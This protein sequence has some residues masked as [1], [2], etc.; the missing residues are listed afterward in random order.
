MSTGLKE[1]RILSGIYPT[2]SREDGGRRSACVEINLLVTISTTFRC[3]GTILART[4]A[5]SVEINLNSRPMTSVK[6]R[7]TDLR[8]AKTR[9]SPV[10]EGQTKQCYRIMGITENFYRSEI[11]LRDKP[12]DNRKHFRMRDSIF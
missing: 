11:V 4:R 12:Q 10:A 1:I 2:I 3:K 8:E 5:A 6:G 9:F 7:C